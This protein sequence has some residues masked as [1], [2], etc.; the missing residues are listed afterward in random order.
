MPKKLKINRNSVICGTISNTNVLG[1]LDG[2]ERE[3]GTENIVEK[4][5]EP[6]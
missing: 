1:V 6:S 3:N 2:K 4:L 5:A